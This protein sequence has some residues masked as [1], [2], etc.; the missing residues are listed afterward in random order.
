MSHAISR[1]SYGKDVAGVLTQAG[2]RCGGVTQVHCPIHTRPR[3][4]G[5]RVGIFSGIRRARSGSVRMGSTFARNERH[6]DSQAPGYAHQSLM[7]QGFCWLSLETLHNAAPALVTFADLARA[8]EAGGEGVAV[9]RGPTS[10]LCIPPL[11]K[12][13][14]CP[15]L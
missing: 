13:S 14:H 4:N 3:R 11:T 10:S 15:R 2:K 6:G 5:F 8:L 9:P 1:L 12:F 7:I